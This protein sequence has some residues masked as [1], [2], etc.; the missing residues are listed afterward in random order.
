VLVVTGLSNEA[1]CKYLS[2]QQ[3]VQSRKADGSPWFRVL[4]AIGKTPFML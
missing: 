3:G 2:S 4:V 1:T